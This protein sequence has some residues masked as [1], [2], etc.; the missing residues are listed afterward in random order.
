MSNT[1]QNG[2]KIVS[3]IVPY[4]KNEIYTEHVINVYS[5]WDGV[6]MLGEEGQLGKFTI[7]DYETMWR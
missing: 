4:S 3:M 6:E 1:L 2:V 5:A 7:G